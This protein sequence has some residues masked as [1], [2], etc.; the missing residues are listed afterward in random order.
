VEYLHTHG[1]AKC[2][3]GGVTARPLF[4]FSLARKTRR[5]T[6]DLQVQHNEGARAKGFSGADSSSD[7]GGHRSRMNWRRRRQLAAVG[8]SRQAR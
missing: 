2:A 6:Q 4:L 1:H 7:P 5:G 8:P 3:L